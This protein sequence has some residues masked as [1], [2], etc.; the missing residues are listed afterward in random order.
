MSNT[1]PT[2]ERALPVDERDLFKRLKEEDAKLVKWWEHIP[3]KP[4]GFDRIGTF[5]PLTGEVE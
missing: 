1:E 3:E 4:N 5:N 2:S